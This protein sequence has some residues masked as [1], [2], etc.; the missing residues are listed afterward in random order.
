MTP[1]M[2]KKPDR[3]I[4]ADDDFGALFEQSLRSPKQGEVVTGRGVL[5]FG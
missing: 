3:A 4:G 2:N 5:V 1:E